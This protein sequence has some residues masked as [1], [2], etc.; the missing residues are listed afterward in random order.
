MQA[1]PPEAARLICSKVERSGFPSFLALRQCSKQYRSTCDGIRT[2]ISYTVSQCP[3]MS[4]YLNTLTCLTSAKITAKYGNGSGYSYCLGIINGST[5]ALTL[6]CRRTG[7]NTQQ[8]VTTH[9]PATPS[10]SSRELTQANS[11]SGVICQPHR[12]GI[13]SGHSL[14][15]FMSSLLSL[16]TVVIRSIS[17]ATNPSQKPLTPTLLAGLPALKLLECSRLGLS[18]L[19]ISPCKMLHMLV[20]KGN[21]LSALKMQGCEALVSLD[22][23]NNLLSLIDASTC[24]SLGYLTCASN[25]LTKLIVNNCLMLQTLDCRNNNISSGLDVS[26][27]T[28]LEQ[29]DCTSSGLTALDVRRC[30]RLLVLK[31]SNNRFG[32]ALK[33]STALQKLDCSNSCV[34]VIDV[35]RCTGLQQLACQG[36]CIQELDLA[37]CTSLQALNCES[38]TLSEL[39][40]HASTRLTQLRCSKNRLIGSLNLS[41]CSALQHVSCDNNKL[42]NLALPSQCTAL[43]QLDCSRNYL[44]QLVITNS[45]NLRS[46]D[47]SKNELESMSWTGPA[48]QSLSCSSNKFGSLNLTSCTS[49]VTLD[50]GPNYDMTA[51]DLSQCVLLQSFNGQFL[52]KMIKLDASACS[53]LRILNVAFGSLSSMILPTSGTLLELDCT[54]NKLHCLDLTA[55][56]SLATLKCGFNLFKTLDVSRCV[57]LRRLEVNNSKHLQLIQSAVGQL[58]TVCCNDCPSLKTSKARYGFRAPSILSRM[59]QSKVGISDCCSTTTCFLL[60]A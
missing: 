42:A 43:V 32:F 31:C 33:L 18:L 53:A 25:T 41:A 36:N 39:D 5:S 16:H 2:H 46:L 17:N 37:A 49:L 4:R 10:G 13:H 56:S 3:N 6:T 14:Q 12:L 8:H 55:C 7:D 9:G 26:L 22:C 23:G 34:K 38:N 28:R 30:T 21:K 40:I 48:L 52:S 19:D 1:L 44:K 59:P 20:C 29:I 15:L 24:T 35:A 57:S 45:V 11:F 54:R 60:I 50:C 47:C 51:I 58:L 27:C